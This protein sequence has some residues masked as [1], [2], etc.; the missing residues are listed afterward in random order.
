MGTPTTATMFK[1][2][3]KGF[4]LITFEHELHESNGFIF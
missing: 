2:H 1:K 4:L 3:V